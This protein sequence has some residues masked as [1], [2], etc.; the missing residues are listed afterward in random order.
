MPHNKEH[1]SKDKKSG[2]AQTKGRGVETRSKKPSGRKEDMVK[3]ADKE[4]GKKKIVPNKDLGSGKSKAKAPVEPKQEE[5]KKTTRSERIKKR[6]DKKFDKEKKLR[7]KHTKAI[8]EG[9][10]RKAKRIGKRRLK[11]QE[12]MHKLDTKSYTQAQ[13]EKEKAKG[14]SKKPMHMKVSTGMQ[15]SA[16]MPDGFTMDRPAHKLGYI[17]K[18]GAGRMSPGKM[19]DMTAMKMMHGDAAA[20]YYDGAGMYMNGA[21]KYEGASKS[22]VGPMTPGHG[23]APGHTHG[24]KTEGNVAFS[25]GAEGAKLTDKVTQTKSTGGSTSSGSTTKIVDKGDD[26]FY[27]N[28]ISS[29]K[30]MSDMKSK[31]IDPRDKKA[32]LNYGNQLHASRQKSSSGGSTTTSTSSSTK[33]NPVTERSIQD[34]GRYEM[35]KIIGQDNLSRY[36]QEMQ[37]VQDSVQRGNKMFSGMMSANPDRSPESIQAMRE[38]SGRYGNQ[39]ANETRKK[40]NIP[41]VT[42]RNYNDGKSHATPFHT[43]YS[44]TASGRKK[45]TLNNPNAPDGKSTYIVRRGGGVYNQQ[46]GRDGS[47]FTDIDEVFPKKGGTPKMPKGPMKYGMQK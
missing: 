37:A 41:P 11:N 38:I 17:Q 35:K 40:F 33:S 15:G 8:E 30:N 34:T 16:K 6:A 20:K 26:V 27:N 9:K 32:V 10:D 46:Y 12:R 21:P 36:A 39:A 25:I 42:Y 28:L 2:V 23:G 31:G 47:V 24:N 1:K 14:P 7:Q 4:Y 22:Y 43:T 29:K 19:G 13:K 44:A 5:K 18:L 3:K 45:K